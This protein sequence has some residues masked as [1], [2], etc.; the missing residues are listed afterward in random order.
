MASP[1]S[2]DLALTALNRFERESIPPRYFLE[3]AFVKYPDISE[4]D[5]ALAVHLTNGVLRWRLQLDW[6]IEQHLR[7]PFRK[8]EPTVLN[9]IRIAL[10]QILFMDRI[11]YAAAVNEAVKQAKKIKRPHLVRFVNGLLRQIIRK[12][13]STPFPDQETDPVRYYS[14]SYSYPPWL[15]RKWIAEL[16][17]APASDLMEASNQ[18]PDLVIRTNTLKISR[19]SLTDCLKREGVVGVPTPYS[20]VGIRIKEIKGPI[21][22]LAAFKAGLFQVQGEAA[23][24]CTMLLGPL[25]GKR[26]LDVC[27]GVG[28]KTTLLAELVGPRGGVIGLDI[29]RVSL[30]RLAEAAR[31]LGTS[32]IY[33]ILYDATRSMGGLFKNRF[34][35]ILVDSPCSG[36]GTISK[37]PDIKWTKTEE[38]IQQLSRDQAQILSRASELLCEGGKLLYVTCT[39][40]RQENEEVIEGFLASHQWMQ[41]VD[42]RAVAPQWVRELIDDDGFFRSYPHVH[43][44]DG[45]FAAMLT[46]KEE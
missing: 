43:H 22:K 8:V 23:Q 33:P 31:R 15:V 34:Q 10:Y 45:F 38:Q 30:V 17:E 26:V 14:V 7:F 11:P 20:P 19:D 27:A 1:S 41:L 32:W 9:I 24:V 46:K 25:K 36:L 29:R 21:T 40:S 16:G 39:I 13:D 3:D 44:M 37:R 18:I 28:G 4:R 6:V 12:K 2:R 42:L 35:Y 5:R